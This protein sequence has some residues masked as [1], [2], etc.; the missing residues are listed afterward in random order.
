M[1]GHEHA[2]PQFEQLP[3]FM[4]AREITTS[5]QPLDFDRQSVNAEG[6]PPE[7]YR[8]HRGMSTNDAY[9]HHG[10]FVQ[11]NDDQLYD[12]KRQEAESRPLA[13]DIKD[14]GVGMPVLL[15]DGSNPHG[16]GA[17]GRRQIVGGHHRVAVMLDH[18][19]DQLMPVR[20]H[21]DLR[22][23]QRSGDYDSP[24]PP[25]RG[26]GTP[27]PPPKARPLGKPVPYGSKMVI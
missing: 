6:H 10:P 21:R 5:H 12:R 11:E 26:T 18:A 1:A 7:W 8:I 3:M 22:D 27:P 4:S 19:P 20:W 16:G 25:E 24:P 13:Q 9:K 14:H 2:G 15:E 23:A 17:Q